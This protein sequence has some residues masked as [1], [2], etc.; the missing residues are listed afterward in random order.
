MTTE[1]SQKI[2]ARTVERLNSTD[3]QTAIRAIADLKES[4]NVNYIPTLVELL[5]TTSDPEIKT[6]VHMLLAEIKQTEAVPFLIQAIEN[7]KYNNE[8]QQL[9]SAC[10]E[11]GLDFSMH[12]SLFINL[13][14]EHDLMIAFEAYTVITNMSGKISKE[15]LEKE[16]GKLKEA[17]L[18][19]NEQKKEL[20]HD[21]LHFLPAFERGIEPQAY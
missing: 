7:K 14:I 15:M 8:L 6:Q 19:T 13:V 20:M 12:L 1:K 21:L 3:A 4:G 18:E 2:S 16:S 10:W 5:H 11:N 17:I 9:V